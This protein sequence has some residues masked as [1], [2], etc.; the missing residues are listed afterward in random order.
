[1]KEVKSSRH[2]RFSLYLS[3]IVII[4]VVFALSADWFEIL[5]L[6]AMDLY[7]HIRPQITPRSDILI[8]TIDDLSLKELGV[9]PWPRRF[10]AQLIDFLKKAGARII[11][12]DVIFAD[13]APDPV[14][15]RMLVESTYKAGNVYYA[16][17][18]SPQRRKRAETEKVSIVVLTD[19]E[20]EMEEILPQFS[21][22]KASGGGLHI[23]R[24]Q[25]ATIP[26][27]NLAQVAR[28]IGNINYEPE[29]DG[30][31]RFAQLVAEY[32]G[33]YYPSLS[34]CMAA[35]F[36]GLSV[37]DIEVGKSIKLGNKS[38][39]V[40][41][42]GKILVNYVGPF[43]RFKTESYYRV[44][45]GEIPMEKFKDK[46]VLV[47]STATGV[48]DLRVT[49]F[50]ANFP[51][52]G[53]HANIINSILEGNYILPLPSFVGLMLVV[54]LGL[55][56]G[57]VLPRLSPLFNAIFTVCVFAGLFVAGVLLF[58]H[59]LYLDIFYPGSAVV[60]SYLSISLYRF[61]TEER[62]KREIKTMFSRYVA[63]AVVEE[64]LSDPSKLL[65]GGTKRVITVLFADL[66][67]FTSISEKMRPEEV[68]S[69]LNECLTE[70]SEVILKYEG[71]LDKFI[72][73]AVLAF[74]GAPTAHSDDAQRAVRTAWEMQQ[75]IEE[76]D[77]RHTG[78]IHGQLKIGIGINTGEVVVG[79]IGSH[80]RMDYTVIGDSVNL[81]QR[82]E[83]AA[84]GGQILITESTYEFVKDIVEAKKLEPIKVKG[85]EQPVQVYEVMKVK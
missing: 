35:G 33:R 36:L 56:M 77:R 15:D 55:L 17:F 14:D 19:K 5:R 38:I 7:F 30:V 78:G 37:E 44:L 57:Y 39:P 47:G 67:G 12:F 25:E 85:K 54:V 20:R 68:V 75:R 64:I 6:K 84:T 34:L 45:T 29:K 76:V 70:M 4:F 27:F 13:N 61:I 28:G 42:E 52:V 79:N 16:M 11:G 71:T 58:S 63:P 9:W 59:H 3:I 53:V 32:K 40:N 2:A 48:Y 22:S 66:R 10:H 83:D 43:D 51:G 26:I 41:Q 18:F 72:G 8:I 46:I 74:F 82:L 60:F 49:P 65:L 31:I 62:E 1:M 80:K 69:L 50:S 81:G 23:S 24:A 73:D 21:I